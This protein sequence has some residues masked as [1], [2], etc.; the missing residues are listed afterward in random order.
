MTFLLAEDWNFKSGFL[1]TIDVFMTCA[2][3]FVVITRGTRKTHFRPF[4]KWYLGSTVFVVAYGFLTGDA[5]NSNLF[6]QGLITLG[7]IPT[8]ITMMT[9]K[10][11]T[12][13]FITWGMTDLTC[14]I[15]LYPVCVDGNILAI[16]YLLRGVIMI[17]LMLALM[18]YYE[19][20]AK[21]ERVHQTTAV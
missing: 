1:N 7:Y 11:N 2:I 3:V 21:R 12:E 6:A 13:S 17:S 8:I 18:M 14:L 20:R 9:E 15:A 16:V 19:L 10:R 4:E 5:W